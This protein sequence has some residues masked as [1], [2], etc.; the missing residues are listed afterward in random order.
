M[1]RFEEGDVEDRVDG[2]EG[3]GKP[4]SV[5]L[6]AGLSDDLVWAKVLLG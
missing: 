3:I 2:A 1:S 5:G 6:T 4:E